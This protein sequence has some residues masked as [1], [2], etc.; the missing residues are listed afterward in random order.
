M[1]ADFGKYDY[2]AAGNN[3][4]YSIVGRCPPLCMLPDGTQAYGSNVTDLCIHASDM[5]LA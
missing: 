4:T 2:V 1:V 5:G 3:I